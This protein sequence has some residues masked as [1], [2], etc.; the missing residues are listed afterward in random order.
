MFSAIFQVNNTDCA[1]LKVS[2]T[3]P[4]MR[5]GLIPGSGCERGGLLRQ[6]G[7]LLSGEFYPCMIAQ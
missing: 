1:R 7:M 5:G 4:P 2:S 6:R 3:V